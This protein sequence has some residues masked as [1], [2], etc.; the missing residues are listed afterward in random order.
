MTKEF[1]TY[2][3]DIETLKELYKSET[4]KVTI[5]RIANEYPN[6]VGKYTLKV[7]RDIMIEL[8]KQII[9]E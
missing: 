1:E 7:V 9:S 5:E 8:N 2:K 4:E 6:I 3:S